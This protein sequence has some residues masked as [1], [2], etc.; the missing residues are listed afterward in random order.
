MSLAARLHI[1]YLESCEMIL[2]LYIPKHIHV[3]TFEKKFQLSI[4][5]DYKTRLQNNIATIS[6]TTV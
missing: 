6:P 5:I 3:Y 4:K 1:F 2:F